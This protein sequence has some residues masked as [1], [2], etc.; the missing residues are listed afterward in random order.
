MSLAFD[1]AHSG[2]EIQ[3]SI[4]PPAV[5]HTEPSEASTPD[6]GVII[7]SG[8]SRIVHMNGRALALMRLFGDAHDLWPNLSSDAMPSILSEFC[9]D[10][11]KELEHRMEAGEWAQLEM[12]RVCHMV[13]PPL[14]LRG[15]AVPTGGRREPHMIVTLQPWFTPSAAQ[16]LD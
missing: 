9:G 16:T 3:T 5:T 7:L 8:T 4:A 14:L 11:L 1:G 6:S 12:R 13:T 2:R 10:I 15:F